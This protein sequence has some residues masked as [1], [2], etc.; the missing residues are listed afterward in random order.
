MQEVTRKYV[1]D[2]ATVYLIGNSLVFYGYLNDPGYFYGN[3]VDISSD[4]KSG[5][6]YKSIEYANLDIDL[7][8]DVKEVAC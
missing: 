4:L 2:L 1:G 5:K 6:A 3:M 7:P 8:S